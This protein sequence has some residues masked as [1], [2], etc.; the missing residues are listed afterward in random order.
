MDR[1]EAPF[2]KKIFLLLQ[3]KF[4]EAGDLGPGSIAFDSTKG[5]ERLAKALL[6]GNGHLV[7]LRAVPTCSDAEHAVGMRGVLDGGEHF[8]IE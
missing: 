7:E 1:A 2:A 6:R 5:I 4:I 3:D 8:A